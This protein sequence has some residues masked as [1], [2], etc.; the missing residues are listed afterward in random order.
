MRPARLW[1]PNFSRRIETCALI[2]RSDT[3]RTAAICLLVSPRASS[4][5]TSTWRGVS[6]GLVVWPS[7]AEAEVGDGF[8][9]VGGAILLAELEPMEG[10]RGNVLRIHLEIP[11]QCLP[12]VGAAETVRPERQEG[13]GHP[14]GDLVGDGLHVVAGGDD[15]QASAEDL[16]YVGDPRAVR[17]MLPVP[18]LDLDG[19]VAQL[20]AAGDAVDVRRDVELVVEQLLRPERLEQ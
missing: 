2:A 6:L 1:T 18:A 12:S 7:G 20:L 4:C 15:R 13:L 3:C 16:G 19:V 14:A 8:C 5:M 11:P 10:R 17:R 9:D